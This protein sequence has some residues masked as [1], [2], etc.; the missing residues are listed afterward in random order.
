MAA[1]N[2][3][4]PSLAGVSLAYT[5][6]ESGGDYIENDG[7]VLVFFRLNG[8]TACTI[9]HQPVNPPA[10]GTAFTALTA[11]LSTSGSTVVFGPFPQGQHNDANGRVNF[12]YSD[13]TDLTVSAVRLEG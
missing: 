6:A 13:A 8:A 12:T 3:K 1:I 4:T 5:A 7:N 10:P 11:T 2:I 9:T